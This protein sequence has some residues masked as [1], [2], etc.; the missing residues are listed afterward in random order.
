M[1]VLTGQNV[2]ELYPQIIETFKNPDLVQAEDSR[3]GPVLVLGG[4][5]TLHYTQPWEAVLFD[6]VRDANP[7]LHFFDA[8][9]ILTDK[10]NVS[11]LSQFSTQIADYAENDGLLFGAYGHRMRVRFGI[12]QLQTVISKLKVNPKDRR[13]VIGLWD[14]GVDLEG[15]AKDHPCNMMAIPR[16]Q[17]NGRLSMTIYNRSNDMLW[18]ATGAN[19]VQF[20]FLQQYIGMHLGRELGSYY[21]VTNNP[22]IYTGFGPWLKVSGS[23]RE[24]DPYQHGGVVRHTPFL[25]HG[26]TPEQWDED[27][28]QFMEDPDKPLFRTKFFLET[29]LKLWLSH[30]AYKAKDRVQAMNMAFEIEAPDWRQ[31]AARWLEKRKM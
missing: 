24:L 16:V 15:K 23:P 18:G 8:L 26:E 11:F 7:F 28:I 6:Q 31:A 10:N 3:N 5:L 27:L 21:Q 4:P 20:S 29:V 12:D 1:R 30:K 19:A 17:P 22:H 2:N 9:F 14:P 13:A 25:I